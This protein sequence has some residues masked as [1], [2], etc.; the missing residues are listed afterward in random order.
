MIYNGQLK[1]IK[2]TSEFV[3]F[4]FITITPLI[5]L[6]PLPCL[7]KETLRNSYLDWNVGTAYWKANLISKWSKGY[8][9]LLMI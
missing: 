2:M 5:V 7:S 3:S 1:D 9:L 4:A 6:L 8:P